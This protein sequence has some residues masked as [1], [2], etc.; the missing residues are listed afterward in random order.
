MSKKIIICLFVTVSIG[1]FTPCCPAEE[2]VGHQLGQFGRDVSDKVKE[3]YDEGKKDVQEMYK[4][5]KKAGQQAYQQTVAS[6]Q[7][8]GKEVKK[9]S[10]SFWSRSKA[11]MQN[12]WQDIKDGFGKKKE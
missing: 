5:G 3:G 1:S 11:K 6:G 2:S 4:D 12:F 8:A 10:K 9:G 7:E